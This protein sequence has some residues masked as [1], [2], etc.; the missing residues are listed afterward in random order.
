MVDFYFYRDSYIFNFFIWFGKQKGYF[1]VV[2][3]VDGVFFG[4]VNE[5]CV[6]FVLFLNVLE[7]VAS[8]DD[9]FL[10]SGVN[11]KEDYFVM[12]EYGK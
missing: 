5:V 1:L 12:L 7:R 2:L 8:L 10:I 11:C 9:N 3:G 6:W 4:K